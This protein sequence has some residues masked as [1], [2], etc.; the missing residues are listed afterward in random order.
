LSR[1]RRIR[2]FP[3]LGE[4]VIDGERYRVERAG[5]AIQTIDVPADSGDGDLLVEMLA[6]PATA[7]LQ[8]V[9]RSGEPAGTVLQR[10]WREE[11]ITV[12]ELERIIAVIESAQAIMHGRA[13]LP[14]FASPT[15]RIPA[16]SCWTTRTGTASPS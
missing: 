16:S 1:R 14:S 11:R 4:V 15:S 13:S 3:G 7:Y 9:S 5:G 10:A 8:P 2:R 6:G 12:A